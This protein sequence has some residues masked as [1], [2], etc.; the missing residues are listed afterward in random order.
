M[1]SKYKKSGWFRESERHSL[2]RRGIKTTNNSVLNRINFAMSG[3]RNVEEYR[4]QLYGIANKK[5]MRSNETFAEFMI[6]RF[7][8]EQH[9][10]YMGEWADRFMSG[11]PM[12]Y[13]D[14][15]SSKIY[16]DILK[17]NHKIDF[18]KTFKKQIYAGYWSNQD[19]GRLSFNLYGYDD[20][21]FEQTKS[22]IMSNM[23]ANHLMPMKKIFSKYGI[24]LKGFQWYS[25]KAYNFSGDSVDL[26]VKVADKNK[27]KS[28]INKNKDEIQKRL[29][30]NKSYDGYMALTASTVDE[31]LE[32]ID[33]NSDVDTMVIS[34]IQEE[35]P[36]DE[37]ED[38]LDLLVFEDV[39]EQ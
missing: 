26:V 35:H 4:R 31:V 16:V 13:M 24:D 6:K 19:G 8:N 14:S 9:E 7:P 22:Q 23:N 15:E 11:D 37:R 20:I 34:Y 39:D 27:L 30:K 25:P 1:Q 17:K 18:A 28:F 12:N 2:A 10:S 36:L 5:G 33:K 32:K 3:K 29:D 38:F 21:D